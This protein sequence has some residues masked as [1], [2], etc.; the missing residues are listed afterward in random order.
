MSAPAT[1]GA[2]RQRATI[3]AP[4][5]EPDGAG[6]FTRRYAPLARVWA[7]IAPVDGRDQFVEQRQEQAITHLA[8]IRWRG[9]VTSQMRLAFANRKLLI[10][11]IY[12]ADETRRFLT[13]RCEEIS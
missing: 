7:R 4:I 9:D 8:T 13:C 2:L 6:G 1:I 12:D 11:A 10:Q 3:E 5:D